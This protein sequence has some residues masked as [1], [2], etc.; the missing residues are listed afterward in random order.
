MFQLVEHLAGRLPALLTIICGRDLLLFRP[1]RPAGFSL[2]LWR[3]LCRHA[4]RADGMLNESTHVH[5]FSALV[6]CLYEVFPLA[7]GRQLLP[8]VEL[9]REL[10]QLSVL[11]ELLKHGDER[12]S[13][14]N[15][16]QHCAGVEHRWCLSGRLAVQQ[17]LE[18]ALEH[19]QRTGLCHTGSIVELDHMPWR[20]LQLAVGGVFVP[21]VLDDL[22]L[23]LFLWARTPHLELRN[24]P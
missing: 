15:Q 16:R 9:Y 8:V 1:L 19:R 5:R 7:I 23:H 3:H 10:H 22:V 6:A 14:G 21:H 12:S 24:L 11:L 4:P 17:A 18:V 13:L 2:R 20:C